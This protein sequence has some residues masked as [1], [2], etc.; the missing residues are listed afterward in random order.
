MSFTMRGVPAVVIC[1]ICVGMLPVWR[2]TFASTRCV[3]DL[4]WYESAGPGISGMTWRILQPV[5][6]MLP[7]EGASNQL[8]RGSLVSFAI[9][10]IGAGLIF[11]SE[12]L[13]ARI[14]GAG[15][16]G[17]FAT[18]MAWLQV[19]AL[20]A[21]VGSNN[22]LL[23]FVPAYVATSDWS[24]LH[25]LMQHCGRISIGLGLG[26][27][28]VSLIFLTALGDRI[29]GE[30]RWAYIIGMVGLPIMALSLQ[31]QAILRGLHRVAVALSPELIIR[32]IGLIVLV[33]ALVWVFAI[34]VT[35]PHV[36]AMNGLAVFLAYLLGR[37]WQQRAMPVQ[38]QTSPAVTQSREWLRIAIPLSLIAGMHL[39][40]ARLDIILLGALIGHEQ[41]G[42]YAAASRVADLIV[43]ALASANVIV[44]PLI[45]GLHVRN[46]VA[47]MQ[48]MLTLLAKG[49]SLLTIPLVIMVGLFGQPILG[50]FGAGYEVAYLPLLILVCGQVINA[51]SGPV[52]FVL[53][54]TGQQMKMLQILAL[55]TGLNLGLNLLLIPPL[56]L[57]GAAIATASTTVF[58]NLFMR[59]VVRQRL[60]IDASVLVLLRRRG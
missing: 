56:G 15:G 38:V 29:T 23:R 25:G 33:S 2:D 7:G 36:L 44:A 22:L 51:L 11:M 31:R 13:L 26:M 41:A 46:D 18:V 30:T 32:P 10:G 8:V 48:Q 52:D 27:L 42:H 47:G 60:G 21:L 53:A 6:R 58:W 24:R 59:R 55:A 57:M 39:L 16:Y 43:F 35:A 4:H 45:A 14:M 3:R 54:M 12:I 19:L 50:L 37:Y 1:D 9:Q 20:V 17:L 40:I 5:M 34:P 28:G 49:V